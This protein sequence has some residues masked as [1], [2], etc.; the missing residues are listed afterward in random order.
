MSQNVVYM[1]GDKRDGRI[2]DLK[3][4][5]F[6]DEIDFS[7]FFPSRSLAEGFRTREMG[8]RYGE[9][10]AVVEGEIVKF[11]D[12]ELTVAFENFLDSPPF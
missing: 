4:H 3:Q 1:I 8:D 5:Y 6:K 11:V 12:N 10:Y 9:D 7:C 2:L